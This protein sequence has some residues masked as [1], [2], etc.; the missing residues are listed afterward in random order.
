[1]KRAL[2]QLSRLPLWA[3]A[4]LLGCANSYAQAPPLDAVHTVAAATQGVPVEETFTTTTAGTYQVTLTDLGAT[5]LPTPAPLADVALAVTSGD[6]IVGTPIT[7]AGSLQFSATANTTYV[8][9]VAGAPGT[10]AGSG[11][12]SIQVTGGCTEVC[13]WQANLAPPPT[14]PTANLGVLNDTFT[15]TT[16]GQYQITLTDLQLPQAL[17]TLTVAVAA[18][19]SAPLQTLTTTSSS[20]TVSATVTLQAGT[21]DIFGAGQ[22]DSSTNAGLYGVTVAPSGGGAPIYGNAIPVGAVTAVSN[23]ALT[24]LAAG[25]YTLNLADLTYPNALTSLGAAITLNGQSAAQLTATGNKTFTATASDYHLFAFGIASNSGQGSY[26]LTLQPSTG[27]P[28]ISIARA[29]VPPSGKTSSGV[30]TYAYSFDATAAS[31]GTY[32]LSLADFSFPAQFDALSVVAVQ[33][34]AVLGS[35]LVVSSSPESISPAAG[36]V[37]LLVFA[38]PTTSGGLFGLS[39]TASGASTP[40]FQT[41]QGVGQLF[42]V[43]KVTVT[44]AG[45][46]KVNVSDLSFPSPFASLAVIVTQGTSAFGNI[47][48]SG[49]FDFTAAAP[50][51]YFVNFIAQPS[52]GTYDAG[53]YAIDVST[54]PPAPAPTITSFVA[55]ATSVTS[56]G[57]VTLNWTSQNAT[58]CTAS[59][60]WSGAEGTS[61]PVTSP[62]ITSS[63]T[64]TL[65]CTGAGGTTSPQS[66]T[67]TIKSSGGGGGGSISLSVVAFL[68]CLVLFQAVLRRPVTLR[69][70]VTRSPSGSGLAAKPVAAIVLVMALVAALIT[71]CGG[72][73][74]RL[75]RHMQLGRQFYAAGNFTKANIEFRNAMQIDPKDLGARLMAAQTAE[76]LGQFRGAYGLY[77]SVIDTDTNNLQ[78]R[79]GL[80][81]LLILTAG[82]AKEGLEIIKPVL[83]K[84]PD[85]PTLLMLRGAARS[86]LKDTDGA[87]ADADRALALDPKNEDAVA[88][89]AALDQHDGDLAGAI[90]LVSDGVARMPSAVGL[91]DILANLYNSNQQPEKAEEQ[92]RALISLKPDQLVFRNQLASLYTRA[93]RLDDAQKVMSD[94]VVALPA[95]DQAKLMLVG[96]LTQQ[97]SVDEAERALQRFIDAAPDDYDLR[98][99]MGALLV[100]AKQ[101]DKANVAYEEIVKRADTKPEGLAARDRLAAIA[102]MQQRETDAHKLIDEVLKAN[103][104]DSD[105]LQLRGELSL[106]HGDSTGAIAD[107]RA[108]LRDQ[109]RSVGANSLLAR[110]LSEHGDVA[111]AEEPLR[112]AAAVAPNDV[113]VHLMLS[114]VLLRLQRPEQAVTELEDAVHRVPDADPLRE[115]LIHA[116][117]IKRDLPAAATAADD[118]QAARPN[119]A[120]P[121][122]LGGL[123]ARADNRLDDAQRLFDR[124]LS[125]QPTA[126]D[127]VSEMAHLEMQRGHGAQ[128]VARVQALIAAHPKDAVW[129]N[130]LGEIYVQQSNFA[131]AQATMTQVVRMQPTWWSSYRVLALAKLGAGDAS[132]AIQEYQ[133]ALQVAPKEPALL[134]ELGQLYQRQGRTDDAVGLYDKWVQ[135]DPSSQVAANNLAMLL[136]LFRSDRPSLDRALKLSASFTTSDNA[137][138]LDTN[139][140]VHFK[141]G[142][143]T[144]ALSVLQRAAD[145]T[146]KSQE[147]RYHLG[148]T[149]LHSGQPDRARADLE[150]A[151][152]GSHQ[153]VGVDE[154][155]AVLASLK[156]NQAGAG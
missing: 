139:G 68:F 130:L 132:G 40:A 98:L 146:P 19:G 36:P 15:V 76:K 43:D 71:G 21:Y 23:A 113:Q 138:L 129:Q 2:L 5:Q 119:I 81:R 49:S 151:L 33:N 128:A 29:V 6:T 114:Q 16:A 96:F 148:M 147:I 150:A 106:A 41:T 85:D 37:S 107:F 4:F 155:R 24:P 25:S 124:A 136:A 116:Y 58:S 20:T 102:V 149:E 34:G 18:P 79:K 88:L 84:H 125:I 3:V 121:Y 140:W 110:A 48:T 97:R 108:V 122:F 14:N 145:L 69:Q 104:R 87:R 1:M 89:R 77:T 115:A 10:V 101:L 95:S 60:G 78:A 103:P 17:D 142:E 111:L 83:E 46:Y 57:T 62:A 55:S 50:G 112:T 56:G 90:K 66:V 35:P 133:A 126:F 127:A 131:A 91:R 105:A 153:F 61:G 52:Q 144:D 11:A 65:T 141:R 80:G 12:I 44:A 99:G 47:L 54:A 30:A 75:D 120:A 154:A 143:Y 92:L 39:L 51:D 93:H 86:A 118:F 72:A 26:A 13:S 70:T 134:S 74:S 94:A 137:S 7:T 64:F 45:T 117:V 53:T 63:T 31:A 135:Q 32:S 59:D 156:N 9:H 100:Q 8:I 109:P 22:A 27:S 152:N 67:V 73:K 123:V 82:R 28:T 42:S 38:E